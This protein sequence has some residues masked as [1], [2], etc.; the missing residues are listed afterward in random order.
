MAL[1]TFDA[2]KHDVGIN[3]IGYMLTSGQRQ[4]LR[5]ATSRASAGE[6][7]YDFYE[8]ESYVALSRFGGGA[9]Q[10]RLEDSGSYGTGVGD[11]R[12]GRWFPARK[13]QTADYG[14]ASEGFFAIGSRLFGI[15][16]TGI[17]QIHHATNTWSRTL[18]NITSPVRVSGN[19]YAFWTQ[20]VSGKQRLFKFNPD[21]GAPEDCTPPGM[22]NVSVV[23]PYGTAMWA[24]GTYLQE[25]D[26]AIVQSVTNASVDANIV[27][28]NQAPELGNVC[29]VVVVANVVQGETPT[30]A[31]TGYTKIEEVLPTGNGGVR[32]PYTAVFAKAADPQ[33]VNA[34]MTGF[35]ADS[36][37]TY[38]LYLFE[39]A[40]LEGTYASTLPIPD[41]K[42]KSAT[43]YTTF[44]SVGDSNVFLPWENEFIFSIWN[45]TDYNSVVS[46]ITP[47]A[48]FTELVDAAPWSGAASNIE[49]SWKATSAI[50]DTEYTKTSSPGGTAHTNDRAAHITLAYRASRFDVDTDLFMVSKTNDDG[51]TWT[52][53]ISPQSTAIEQPKSALA[54]QGFLWFTTPQGLYYLEEA[55]N[56]AS[57]NA[58]VNIK[59][60]FD[61]WSVP[62]DVA[63]TGDSLDVYE[64]LFY[65]NLGASVR[66]FAPGGQGRHLWPPPDWATVS[67]KVQSLAA[68]EGGV[69]FGAAGFLW[70]Y[71][72]RGFHPL[73]AE[74]AANA[75][76]QLFWHQGN[77]YCSGSKVKYI[78]FKYP[79]ARPDVVFSDGHA[80]DV[81]YWVSSEL[82]F[83]KVNVLKIIRTFELQGYFV[84]TSPG[85][86]QLHYMTGCAGNPDPLSLGGSASGAT[87]TSIGSLTSAD[88]GVK[89]FQLATPLLCKRLF[90]RVT[91]TPSSTGFPVLQAA[92][93]FGRTMM[94]TNETFPLNLHL[95]TDTVDRQSNKLYPTDDDVE[96]ALTALRNLRNGTTAKY[97]NLVWANPDG[98]TETLVVTPD[99]LTEPAPL[100]NNQGGV[101]VNVAFNVSELP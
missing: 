55:V 3:G 15:T 42:V 86:L 85:T 70:V 61:R 47:E 17:E 1:P 68:S 98:S 63:K 94:P 33:D 26:P 101:T 77:L 32:K 38:K 99:A 44:S 53:A 65:Y 23:A 83:E 92:I 22:S 89:T 36:N 25:S 97:F 82:D 45:Q 56:P 20:A 75:F 54:A 12:Y 34:V 62:Y 21:V 72:T 13:W 39:V 66:Q 88:G 58:M 2:T 73:A 43:P 8:T 28:W 30:P 31:V 100:F 60:P 67:G 52:D 37:N 41:A 16:T 96:D 11:G 95:S 64:G 57:G 29:F 87:W 49:I 4:D 46:S 14:N 71:D 27:N 69:F 80:F 76:N 40:G 48:G 79:S 74:P 19:G 81:G 6:G 35:T 5:P 7:R 9:G 59:G 10:Q 90:L 91:C 93:A 78:E 84:G 24:F 18:G 51:I 50:E